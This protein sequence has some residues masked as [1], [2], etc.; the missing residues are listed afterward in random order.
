MP[1][2]TTEQQPIGDVSILDH[3]FCLFVLVIK[4]TISQALIKASYILL[5]ITVHF[6]VIDFGN[7]Q[8]D[9]SCRQFSVSSFH[10]CIG[11]GEW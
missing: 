9:E 8:N 1:W 4:E 6:E 3:A 2:Q 5:L 7:R 11:T 10:D